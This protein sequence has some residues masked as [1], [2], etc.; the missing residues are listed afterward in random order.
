MRGSLLV[1]IIFFAAPFA[2]FGAQW[3]PYVG[4]SLNYDVAF[5]HYHMQSLTESGCLHDFGCWGSQFEAGM[6]SA[7]FSVYGAYHSSRSSVYGREY[8]MLLQGANLDQVASEVEENAW[9]EQRAL[10]GVRWHLNGNGDY[11]V[12]PVV[13]FAL[14]YGRSQLIWKETMRSYPSKTVMSV[15]DVS[16]TSRMNL[17]TMLE[18]GMLIETHMPVAFTVLAQFHRFE[19]DFGNTVPYV[20]ANRYVVILPSVQLGM[21]YVFPSF[22]LGN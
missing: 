3:S 2:L 1:C 4:G 18:F 14:S 7:N 13:G 21:R 15:T 8:A 5:A 12:K 19:S 10:V 22:H 20:P 6:S 9:D 11:P 16:R 17:G